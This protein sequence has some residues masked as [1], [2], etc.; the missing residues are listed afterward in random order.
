VSSI[1]CGPTGGLP[2]DEILARGTMVGWAPMSSRRQPRYSSLTLADVG[3]VAACVASD[4]ARGPI[5]D[6]SKVT[7][8]RDAL[9]DEA[10][11]DVLLREMDVHAGTRSA[12]V[13]V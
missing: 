6:W 7:I 9:L 1:G 11:R 3:T 5:H 12:V 10:V 2:A 8:S 13:T 4:G